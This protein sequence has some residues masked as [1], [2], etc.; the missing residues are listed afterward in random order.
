MTPI[1]PEAK[2]RPI[3]LEAVKEFSKFATSRKEDITVVISAFTNQ[4]AL[5]EVIQGGNYERI[6][7]SV[8]DVDAK[9]EGF[10]YQRNAYFIRF[11]HYLCGMVDNEI[12]LLAIAIALNYYFRTQSGG[13]VDNKAVVAMVKSVAPYIHGSRY[14]AELESM[15]PSNY[16]FDLYENIVTDTVTDPWD[17]NGYIGYEKPQKDDIVKPDTTPKVYKYG[18][19]RYRLKDTEK[20]GYGDILIFKYEDKSYLNLLKTDCEFLKI[21]YEEGLIVLPDREDFLITIE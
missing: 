13:H 19:L 15:L 14:R 4:V 9:R 21:P 7:I 10:L 3:L 5:L 11:F 2:K 16:P 18:A 6:Y 12:Y 20:L 8:I 1:L 17:K